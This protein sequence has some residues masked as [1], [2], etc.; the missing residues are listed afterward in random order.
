MGLG[1]PV[2][3]PEAASAAGSYRIVSVFSWDGTR[4]CAHPRPGSVICIAGEADVPG[5]GHVEYARDA[6]G[7]GKQTSD[8]CPELSTVG[9]IWVSGGTAVL[10]GKPASTC[11]AKDN[12]DAHY[13]Y[14]I[15]GGTGTLAGASGSGDIVADH[16][17]DRWHGTL[18]APHIVL[19]AQPSKASVPSATPPVTPSATPQPSTAAA[20][21]TPAVAAAAATGSTRPVVPDSA[22]ATADSSHGWSLLVWILV[23]FAIAAAATALAVWVVRRRG[24][25]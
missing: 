15:S 5:L 18:V 13:L 23:P 12:P 14:T 16:G 9:V 20:S 25:P 8:G 10:T 19:V 6:V 4:E 3:E 7:N 1:I 11:G 21:P 17:V 2:L 24:H 22:A